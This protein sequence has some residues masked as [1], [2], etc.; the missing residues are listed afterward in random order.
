[1]PVG[2][3]KRLTVAT[4]GSGSTGGGAG[5]WGWVTEDSRY[6]WGSDPQTTHQA[7]EMTA[8]REVL[9]HFPKDQPLLILSDSLWVIGVFTE[10][11]AVWK[12]NNMKR[13]GNKKI[14]HKELIQEIDKMLDDRDVCWLK[15]QAHAGH[16]LNEMA[17][18]LARLGRL[19]ALKTGQ[20]Y[21]SDPARL[22]HP[23]PP[24]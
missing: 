12:Q 18:C 4:D 7:M 8:V 23:S 1:M 6:R 19:T 5:G 24:H 2:E 11:L 13:A 16:L 3:I 21:R 15:V 20:T 22:G 17:D 9:C 14:A 10:W